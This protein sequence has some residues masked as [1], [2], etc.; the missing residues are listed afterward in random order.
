M[1][2]IVLLCAVV[3]T[4]LGCAARETTTVDPI[5]EIA[6]PSALSKD[7]LN[8]TVYQ[9]T[10]AEFVA[11]ARQT[12]QIATAQ[13]DVALADR[14]F[15]AA[16]EQSPPFDSLPP[17][18]IVDLDETMIDNAPYEARVAI[19]G[20]AFSQEDW[21]KWV[22]EAAAREIPGALDFARACEARGIAVVYLSNRKVSELGRTQDNMARL[23]FPYARD[24]AYYALRPDDRSDALYS[25]T[26]RRA[27]VAQT[28]RIIMLIGDNLGDF[29]EAYSG[30]REQRAAAVAQNLHRLGTQW[31]VL[32]NS[33]YGSWEDTLYKGEPDASDARRHELKVQ[34]LD[35]VGLGPLP[36]QD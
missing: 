33:M 17:A 11:V 20:K 25:K 21:G 14:S 7:L 2:R 10:A 23:E 1:R 19:T 22:D 30:T 18:V 28:H 32:P 8:A 35:P 6:A 4:L 9:Q 26:A 34:A 27:K 16:L 29:T 3:S 13:L 36:V 31:L 5:S 24:N 15:S 12:F